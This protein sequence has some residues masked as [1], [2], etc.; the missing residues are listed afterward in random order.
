M[1]GTI[2]ITISLIFFA[3][4][5]E[6]D[7]SDYMFGIYRLGGVCSFA[8]SS[9]R[10]ESAEVESRRTRKTE[11][12]CYGLFDGKGHSKEVDRSYGASREEIE[13]RGR[14]GTF[15]GQR[16]GVS[17]GFSPKA[18]REWGMVCVRLPLVAVHENNH[19]CWTRSINTTSTLFPR[20]SISQMDNSRRL[21]WLGFPVIL[22]LE[23]FLLI[24]EVS[25]LRRRTENEK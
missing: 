21:F 11:Q 18:W 10:Y 4:F 17:I 2:W 12:S 1:S 3:G 7:T 25:R 23:L 24:A 19:L 16:L 5:S 20:A 9:P 22:L 6:I 8:V 14:V 15:K 13:F